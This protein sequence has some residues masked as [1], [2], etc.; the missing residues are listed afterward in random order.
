MKKI[1][2][3]IILF[4]IFTPR[5]FGADFSFNMPTEIE[6]DKIFTTS[7]LVDTQKT[8]INSAEVSFSYDNS[9]LEFLGFK[10]G[11]VLNLWIVSPKEENGKI[12]FSGIIPGG[13]TGTYD[14][15]HND[16][17]KLVLLNLL[18]KA[19]SKGSAD[20]NF[21]STKAL[22][23]DGL[24]TELFSV[25]NSSSILIRESLNKDKEKTIKEQDSFDNIP[26]LEFK[27]FFKDSDLNSGIPSLLIFHTVDNDSGIAKYQIKKDGKW[28]EVKSP[29]EVHKSF[30]DRSITI[31]AVDFAGNV[32]DSEVVIPGDISLFV[33][34]LSLFAIIVGF[35]LI[36]LLKYKYGKKP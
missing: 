7:I 20:F 32:R 23:N 13:V 22:K 4:C 10:E 34:I 21:I 14:S 1:F 9:K 16:L 24:G 17:Q 3:I 29:L 15:A 26:P 18:F 36:K 25:N 30:F 8:E 2:I 33:F 5:A 12:L 6:Q 11:G 31:R 28:Q 19:N 35:Y 27:V